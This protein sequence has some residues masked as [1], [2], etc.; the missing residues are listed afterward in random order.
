MIN[1][2]DDIRTNFPAL[3]FS[4]FGMEP[5][6]VLTLELYT[7]TGEVF[8]FVGMSVAEVMRKAF[9]QLPTVQEPVKEEPAP[10]PKPLGLFD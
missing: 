3:G 4:L 6:Q 8:S 1:T 9:P 7:P 5:G 2:L 10:V